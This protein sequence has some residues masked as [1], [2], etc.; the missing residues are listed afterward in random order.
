MIKLLR[1]FCINRSPVSM[2]TNRTNDEF[3]RIVDGRLRVSNSKHWNWSDIFS[4][5]GDGWKTGG[6]WQPADCVAR[7]HMAVIIP[8][9]DRDYHLKA[10][11]RHLIP[12]LRRQFLHFRIFVVEQV[13]ITTSLL[14][15]TWG[16][17][18]MCDTKNTQFSTIGYKFRREFEEILTTL[19]F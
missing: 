6:E 13:M 11:L 17:G 3:L 19:Q 9:R 12:I 4:V 2:C 1:F 5:T 8:C 10:L 7:Y 18:I 16:T 14:T 15:M